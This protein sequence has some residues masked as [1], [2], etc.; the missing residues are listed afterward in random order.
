MGEGSLLDQPK[1]V[2]AG[3]GNRVVAAA[4][5]GQLLSLL[6]AAVGICSSLLAA[7]VRFITFLRAGR[8]FCV[9]FSPSGTCMED[10]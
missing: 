2:A 4:L 6:L 8:N 1:A 5:L 3:K 10:L 9:C 7:K